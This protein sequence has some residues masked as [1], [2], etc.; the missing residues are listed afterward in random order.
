MRFGDATTDA[1]AT[2]AI[3]AV[4]PSLTIR[5]S[6]TPPATINIQQG[7]GGPAAPDPLMSILRPAIDFQTISGPV[8]VAPFGDP[9]GTGSVAGW[10]MMAGV[11]VAAFAGLFVWIGTKLK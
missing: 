4:V 5:T 7:G 11:A 3:A 6:F 9:L 2:S 10:A 8:T 1:L